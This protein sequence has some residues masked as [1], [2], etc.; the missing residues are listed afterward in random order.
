MTKTRTQRVELRGLCSP[1]LASALDAIAMSRGMDRN[2]YVV[3]VLEADVKRVL[4]ESSVINRALRGNPLLE[5]VM[6][7]NQ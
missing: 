2:A 6:G 1:E 7:T 4:H 5:E 3:Q